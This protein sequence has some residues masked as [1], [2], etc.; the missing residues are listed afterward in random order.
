M[1]CRWEH[2]TNAITFEYADALTRLYRAS[3]AQ[4][5]LTARTPAIAAAAIRGWYGRYD[6]VTALLPTTN[7]DRD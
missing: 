2:G 7:R 5:G 3:P 1:L 4:L 6:D